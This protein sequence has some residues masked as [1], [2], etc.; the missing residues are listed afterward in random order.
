MTLNRNS[1]E[2]S[3]APLKVLL[4]F[5]FLVSGIVTVLIGQI[6]PILSNRLQL[7]DEQAGYFFTIQFAGS[8]LG[9]FLTNFLAKRFGFV[10]VSVVGC[11]AMAFGVLFLNSEVWLVCSWAF[12]VMGFGIGTT[13]PAINMLTVELNPLNATPALNF[14]NFFWGIG[15]IFCKP[16]V[17]F[18]GT[19]TNIFVPTLVISVILVLI[20]L[21]IA[22]V[23]RNAEP[24][25]IFSEKIE[26]ESFVPIWTTLTAWMIAFFNFVHVGFESGAGGWLTT[27]ASRFP[28][29][30]NLFWLSPT[31]AYFFFFVAGRG[32]AP[33]Y[34]RFIKENIIILL[35]LLV[36]IGGMTILVR[37][38]SFWAIVLGAAI[39]G[40]GTSAVFPTNMA[41]FT[42][43]FGETAT[44]RATPLFI[45]GTLGS[46]L[47][48]QLIG[49]F[50]THYNSLRVG[51]YVLL[52][53]CL[54]LLVLQ[55]LLIF[56]LKTRT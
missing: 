23:P 11:L 50:S 46:T 41:R 3:I 54:I 18:F 48:T 34:A 25:Q 2:V 52:A 37:G 47:I 5:G 32:I 16:F 21:A 13:L 55:I 8:L 42:K 1:D 40:L 24:K 22:V 56:K 35:S 51:M 36:M 12:F 7:N 33:I 44:R 20:A 19:S 31:L 45:S 6:L 26:N 27:Y 43:T 15:A 30:T 39:S 28:L 29:E 17:D 53:S 9:T 38:E 14:L 10:I 49:F 4:H